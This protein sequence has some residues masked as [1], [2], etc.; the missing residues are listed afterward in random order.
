MSSVNLV[1]LDPDRAEIATVSFGFD[2][3]DILLKFRPEDGDVS[4]D[5]RAGGIPGS[6]GKRL[7][8]L[9]QLL[10][11]AQGTVDQLIEEHARYGADWEGDAPPAKM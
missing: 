9:S 5:I 10:E 1:V 7:R 8:R 6:Q 4:V 2:G 11:I 3:P